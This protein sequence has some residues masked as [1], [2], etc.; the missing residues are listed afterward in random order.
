MDHSSVA[1][2]RTFWPWSL[3]WAHCRYSGS[4]RLPARSPTHPQLLLPAAR[5]PNRV[6]QPTAPQSRPAVPP[7]SPLRVGCWTPVRTLWRFPLGGCQGW[8]Q[9]PRWWGLPNRSAAV[10]MRWLFA[11]C[12]FSGFSSI[13]ASSQRS[14][15]DSLCW[16][17]GGLS[18]ALSAAI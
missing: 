4:T 1:R 14:S 8:V 15:A 5:C 16:A 7:P 18:R 17:P 2:A 6:Q 3:R 10:R 13:V 9:Q 11:S 12:S